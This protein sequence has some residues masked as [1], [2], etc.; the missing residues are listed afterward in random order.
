MPRGIPGSGP[1]AKTTAPDVPGALPKHAS[2]DLS[3]VTVVRAKTRTIK[4]KAPDR[5]EDTVLVRVK[6]NTKGEY[7]WGI[8]NAGEVFAMDTKTMRKWPLADGT[9]K[10]VPKEWPVP[11]VDPVVVETPLGQFELPAWVEL[12]DPDEVKEEELVP[13]GHPKAHGIKDGAVL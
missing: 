7:G 10:G 1:R 4:E 12:V 2:E 5:P 13:H 11:D 3:R 8:R 9:V 6:E